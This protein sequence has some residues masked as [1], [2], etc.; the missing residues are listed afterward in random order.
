VH[1]NRSADTLEIPGSDSILAVHVDPEH[2]LLLQRHWGEHARFELPV[3]QAKGAKVVVVVG[4]FSLTAVPATREGNSWVV[5]LPLT[6]GRYVWCWQ[7][8][9]APRAIVQGGDPGT[10][11][12]P[13]LTFVR[14]VRP[15][16]LLS[17]A[18]PKS[19]QPIP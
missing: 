7:L 12:D 5:D 9:G 10:D 2:R 13:S 18:Y 6:E 1:L 14:Y 8:D 16:Q 15:V 19:L 11:G 3:D 4:D 17:D